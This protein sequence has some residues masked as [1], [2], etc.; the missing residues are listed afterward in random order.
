MPKWLHDK[1]ARKARSKGLTG[2]RA[3]AYIYGTLDKIE[4]EG[5]IKEQRSK[6]RKGVAKP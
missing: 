2:D 3:A 6:R 1:L 5:G 4:K